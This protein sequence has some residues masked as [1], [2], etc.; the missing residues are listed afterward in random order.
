MLN[1]LS[2]TADRGRA[3]SLGVGRGTDDS[4]PQ[5]VL[6]YRREKG[7]LGKGE[8]LEDLGVDGGIILR[9]IFKEWD[10]EERTGYFFDSRW[11]QIGNCCEC[12]DEP[13]GSMKFL[14]I[15]DQLTPG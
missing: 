2:R 7:Y 8:R 1:K 5:N 3:S 14:A 15:R 6:R 11:E 12:G 9:W 10:W 13:S 4:S